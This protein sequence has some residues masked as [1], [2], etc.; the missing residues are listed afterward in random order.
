VAENVS[1]EVFARYVNQIGNA[2]LDQIE[3]A[4]AAQAQSA[5]KGVL[6]SLGE[7]L[8]QQGVLTAAMRENVEKKLQAQQT[9]GIR[10]LGN[11]KLIKKLGEG[12]M[13]AVYLAEDLSVGR[14]VAVKVLPKKS[15]SDPDFLAR[16]RREAK[17]AGALNHVNIVGAYTIGEDQGF[18]YIAMEYC[19][20]DPL[21]KVLKRDGP[22]P[23]DKALEIIIQVARGLKH[24]HDHGFIHRDIKPANIMLCMPLR[25][26]GVPPVLQEG[27]VAKILDLGLSKNVDAGEQS[28]VTQMNVALGTPHYISPEQAKGDRDIDGRTDIYSLGATLYHLVTGQT[29]FQ[30][31]TSAIIMAQHVNQKLPNPQDLEAELPDGVVH[32]LQKMLAKKPSER[33]GDCQRLLDDLEM[34]RDGKSPSR[35]AG[36][37]PPAGLRQHVPVER[38]GTGQQA[39]DQVEAGTE[40]P[41]SSRRNLFIAAGFGALAV[42]TL[43]IGLVVSGSRS[44]EQQAAVR[45]AEDK[46][47]AEADETARLAERKRKAEE[48]RLKNEAARLEEGRRKL[49]EE[50]QKLDAARL[51][52]EAETKKKAEASKTETPA[53]K[54]EPGAV[55]VQ[56]DTTT[57]K[58]GEAPALQADAPA[59]KA[60]QLFSGVLK[61]TAPLLAQNKLADAISLLEG[62]AKDPALADAAALIKQEQADVEAVVELRRQ[63]I[64]AL[65]KQVGQQVTL[66]KGGAAFKGKVVNEPKPDVVTLDMGGAQMT[67]SAMQLSLEDVDQYAPP[68][69]N[70][71]LDLRQRGIMYLAAGNV[72]KS[73][74]YFSKPQTLNPGRYLDCITAIETGEIEAVALRAWER[75]EKLFAAKDMLG[76][77]ALYG[78]FERDH[79]K[80]QT[81]VKQAAA[82]KERHEAIEKAIGPAPQLSLD[83]GGGV[84]MQFVLVKPGDFMMGGPRK[85]GGDW[86]ANEGP[87]HK[88]TITKPYYVGRYPVTVAQFAA[89]VHATKYQTECEEAGN[90]AW[91]VK[92]GRWAERTAI[93][94][95]EPGFEQTPDHP[96]VLVS[97]NDTQAFVAWASKQ[98]GRDVRLPSEAQWEYAARGPKS[99]EYPFGEKWDGLKVNHRDAALKNSG[100]QDGGCSNDNDGY[101]FTS[102]VGKFNNASWCG[103]FD[104]SGN[105]WQ[106][107]QDWEAD[108]PSEAQVDPQGPANGQRR[109]A[110][111]GS[112]H[113]S[114]EHCRAAFRQRSPPGNRDAN[115]GLRLAVVMSAPRTAVPIQPAAPSQKPEI[116]APETPVLPPRPPKKEPAAE[117]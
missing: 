31:S 53:T 110:R 72:A 109:I 94:W 83:L 70:A 65:R 58:V 23:W 47:K 54:T 104:M 16:F 85:S 107:V 33:Y 97:W 71:G 42:L 32:V 24:A 108:Y 19:E 117:P 76:A 106:W 37:L 67:F 30:G 18:H 88:V 1:D 41:P 45:A 60:Q 56:P 38:R 43:V 29:P 50:R 28:F 66:K 100:W 98:T 40:T 3:A 51:A 2:T 99:L 34:V 63:A 102:P 10:K 35:T 14:M 74:E 113:L 39:A 22:L 17:A 87:I 11:Y 89:F 81:A 105:V 84:K 75:A 7:V 111:G 55:T 6:L 49:A 114:P 36:P 90:K 79:G 44:S 96:V 69:G 93:N 59:A 101:A 20:G 86:Q 91:S 62:K 115:C 73:K 95:S 26:T 116:V 21:D 4:K 5:K 52:A 46:R 48:S 9:G 27:F 78:V 57:P 92:D 64:E 68:T 103:A 80:T 8:V 25:S 82:L 112:W 15:A 13:G 77:K 12:G 61:E